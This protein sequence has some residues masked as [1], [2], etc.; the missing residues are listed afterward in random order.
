MINRFT[1]KADKNNTN[2]NIHTFLA[3]YMDTVF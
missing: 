1:K 3:L 2:Y